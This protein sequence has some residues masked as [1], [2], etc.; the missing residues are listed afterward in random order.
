M[1]DVDEAFCL[2]LQ[3]SSLF[4]SGVFMNDGGDRASPM[5]MDEM[6]SMVAA[7]D[8]DVS[9]DDGFIGDVMVG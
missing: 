8:C 2:S 3:P 9:K 5:T 7:N 4:A 1:V 6:P